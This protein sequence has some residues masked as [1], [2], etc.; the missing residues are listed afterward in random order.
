MAVERA[1][2]TRRARYLL[3]DGAAVRCV[4]TFDIGPDGGGPA[5]P[6]ILLPT[7]PPHSASWQRMADG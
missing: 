5:V 2:I 4:L 1:H 7:G 6:K 3:R